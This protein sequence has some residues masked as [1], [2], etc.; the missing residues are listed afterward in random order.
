MDDLTPEAKRTIRLAREEYSPSD[1]DK[2]RVQ[3]ALGAG[4]AAAAAVATVSTTEAAAAAKTVGI[5]GAW[6]GLRGVV[7]VLLVASA[8][9]GVYWWT[10]SPSPPPPA[11]MDMQSEPSLPPIAPPAPPLLVS[12]PLPEA[13]LPAPMPSSRDGQKR[14]APAPDPLVGELTV[15]HRAQQA[16]RD[17][18]AQQA[19]EIAQQHAA[20]YPRSQFAMER[21]ALQVFALCALGRKAEARSIASELLRQAPRSPL[22]T[23][24]EESCA[25]K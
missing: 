6:A 18:K 15:L 25:M 22:R 3:R 10:R 20:T 1:E 9:T 24:L 11:R 2:R 17:G 8:G 14:A 12:E 4:L 13:V 23:S 5:L 21:G 16:W 7:G 19:L